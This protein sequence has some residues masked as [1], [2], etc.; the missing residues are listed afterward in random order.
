M[1][2]IVI[3]KDNVWYISHLLTKD[4]FVKEIKLFDINNYLIQKFKQYR[5]KFY[6]QN[7]E[8]FF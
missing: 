6:Q 3:Y 8:I 2:K 5:L 7:K 1:I 4:K